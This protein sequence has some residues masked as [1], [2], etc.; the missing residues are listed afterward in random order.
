MHQFVRLI[1]ILLAL[2]CLG[3]CA[4]RPAAPAAPARGAPVVLA[5]GSA[6]ELPA[7]AAR[8]AR[9]EAALTAPP[10]ILLAAH[11]SDDWLT[12]AQAAAVADPRV[13]AATRAPDGRP[14]RAEVM[15]LGQA[16]AG[17]VPPSLERAC[18]SQRCARVQ[19]YVYPT[20]TT[21]TALVAA[22]GTVLG[23]DALADAQPEI[24][25]DLADLAVQI[26]LADPQVAA[27]FEGL[28]PDAAMATMSATKTALETTSCERSRH[29]CVAPVFRWG[30]SAL[31][32][33][34]DLSEFRLVG[35]AWT[36]QG[37]SG[38]RVWSEATLQDAA[39]ASLCETPVVLEQA[40]WRLSYLLTSSD[41]LELRDLRFQGQPV[42]VSAKVVDW[43]VGYAGRD[44]ERVGF[45]DAIGC[46]VFSAAAVIPYA[47]PQIAEAPGGGFTLELTFRSPHWPQPCNYQY[48]TRA[49]FG[50]DGTIRFLAIN[51]GRGC[52]VEGIYHP[53]L[54]LELPPG[55]DLSDQNGARL[56][57]EGQ[58]IWRPGAPHVLQART[59]DGL[60]ALAPLWDEAEHAYVY[61]TRPAPGE[62]QGDLP[63]IGSCCALDAR[64]GPERFINGESLDGG[65]VVWFVPRIS[66]AERQR[67]WAD[68]A[69]EGGALRPR[70]WPCG[71]GME[72]T[73]RTGPAG[74]GES[75]L[76]QAP[77]SGPGQGRGETGLPHTPR[78][79]EGVG[80][81][82]HPRG[83][84]YAVAAFKRRSPAKRPRRAFGIG[85][86]GIGISLIVACL[87]L[88]YMR[89]AAGANPAPAALAAT[90]ACAR[91]PPFV[92][93]LTASLPGP[94]ALAT[95]RPMR[96]LA[97]VSL[98]GSGR[99]YQHQS[100]DDGGFMGA[101]TFD[102]AGNIYLAPTPRQ[103]LADN[104]PS[105]ATTLW[106]VDGR[107]GVM[108]PF[109]TLP[110]AASER[111][112]FG[113]LGLSYA[114]DLGLLFAGTVIGSTPSV[115]RG[116]V[117]ALS[118]DGQ[119]RATP[120]DGLDAMGVTVVR[121]DRRYLLL[122]G[123]A[124]RPAIV[125]VPLDARGHAAGPPVEIIDLTAGGATASERARKLRFANGE[126]SVDLVS[127]NYTLQVN[128]SGTA[129]LRRAIW[130]Y[131]PHTR[132]W[133][134]ARQAE[135]QAGP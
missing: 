73:S 69:L 39:L 130:R 71:A 50:P 14:L 57:Q 132:H 128:A 120:V 129:P 48:V 88:L 5:G 61:W 10:Y 44:D 125:G 110:G 96:G 135:Q 115:E 32:T 55:A 58:T 17:D 27:A 28:T 70:V 122:A 31:W 19:I 22:D 108:R 21:V 92:Q 76:A 102:E 2:G 89:Q 67:C 62:G 3:A 106:R 114:C 94:L 24:P 41:G 36:D 124:R 60:L 15:A 103:S 113:V 40:G 66:N 54:R 78:P 59:A 11:T 79:R 16:S 30:N 37:V 81:R 42:L 127:F 25:A 90:G 85:H 123:L 109:A 9:L 18:A 83:G 131:D 119:I 95:D 134:V 56:T 75:G 93:E 29:L 47:P 1:V 98:D 91:Q 23:V 117:V 118:T 13:R 105:G 68:T 43:H 63:S 101:M 97:L 112:P 33:I 116:G 65:A 8:K 111:N 49:H 72:I 6:P 86:T 4:A 74:Y 99:S 64:Q 20:N 12:A 52:G 34:V 87:A 82:S 7:V 45:S 38:R 26:A 107:T 80:E 51:E 100:W 126:L 84:G 121:A 77:L 133:T 104:P 46:P 35:A 53:V